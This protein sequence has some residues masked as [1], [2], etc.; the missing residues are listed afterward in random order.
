MSGPPSAAR[1]RAPAPPLPGGRT[2]FPCLRAVLFDRDGTLV[3]DVPYNADPRRVRPMPRAVEAVAAVRA[4]G[5]ATGV[6]SNQS[7]I[8]RGLLTA[9]QVRAVNDRVDAVF[10]PFDVWALCP[11]RPDARCQ[12]RKP[13]PGLVLTAARRLGV[14]PRACAV[15]GDIGADLRAA[16]AAGARAAIVPTPATRIE[17][18]AG[19]PAAAPDLLTA[20]LRLLGGPGERRAVR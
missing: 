16:R 3:H 20:V 9:A 15:I 11:H 6:V 19:D 4:A 7:G 10:G 5:L 13:R 2:A 14:P 12:C 1:G 8:G 18:Y 17:E